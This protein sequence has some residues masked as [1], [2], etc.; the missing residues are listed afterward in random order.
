MLYTCK[1]CE[2]ADVVD[3]VSLNVTACLFTR[4]EYG[5]PVLDKAR[6]Q[7]SC[8]Y[9]DEQTLRAVCTALSPDERMRTDYPWWCADAA[10]PL[11]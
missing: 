7:H 5:V 6:K 4:R 3:P 2:T 1:T 9:F 11:Q 10:P 8:R